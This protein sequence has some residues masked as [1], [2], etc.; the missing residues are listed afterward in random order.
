MV[1]TANVN[2]ISLIGK[3]TR[4]NK[5]A[6]TNGGE[7]AGP[8]PFCGGRDRFRVQPK[9]E[10]GGRW[11][12]RGCGE[13]HWHDAI[14]YIR[15]RDHSDFLTACKT[16]KLN[17]GQAKAKGNPSISS[18][19]SID[20]ST[21]LAMQSDPLLEVDLDW[22]VAA[23]SFCQE[24]EDRLWSA[25]GIKARQFLLR[26]RY[27]TKTTIA[28][29]GLG[30]NPIDH[31]RRWGSVSVWLPR[32]I[33][34]PWQNEGLTKNVRIRRPA[35]EQKYASARGSANAL[36][37]AHTIRPGYPVVMVEGEFD[38]LLLRQIAADAGLKVAV[39]ATGSIT[40]SRRIEWIARLALASEVLVAFDVESDPQKIGIVESA[41][42]WWLDALKPKARRSLPLK[43]DITDMRQAGDRIDLWLAVA[44]DASLIG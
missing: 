26:E 4:L 3:D 15:R 39:V 42:K 12:C 41:A 1:N 27:L 43:H 5:V 30:Y 18:P 2:L 13:N 22:Q 31:Y 29:A 23:R 28:A 19:P 10:G 37:R 21:A 25:E 24:C 17:P 44:L 36:Y 8:C 40:W 20:G 35:C 11:F 34:I 38:A 6:N 7:Y 33:V 9:R 16:L 32:G 14:E